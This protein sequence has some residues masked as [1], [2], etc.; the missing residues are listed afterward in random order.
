MRKIYEAEGEE[1]LSIIKTEN[2]IL[3]FDIQHSDYYRN[4]IGVKDIVLM[5]VNASSGSGK[6]SSETATSISHH[7]VL[8]IFIS[9]NGSTAWPKLFKISLILNSGNFLTGYLLTNL[10]S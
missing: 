10:L 5:G 2:D 8:G 7:H 9:N 1:K 6:P 4:L 3:S